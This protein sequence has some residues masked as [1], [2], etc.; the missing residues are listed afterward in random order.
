MLLLSQIYSKDAYKKLYISI[1]VYHRSVEQKKTK[2][3]FNHLV[4]SKCVNYV[5][6]RNNS[7]LI[8][9]GLRVPVPMHQCLV[10]SLVQRVRI[11]DYQGYNESGGAIIG[12]M[13]IVKSLARIDIAFL[14]YLSQHISCF[15]IAATFIY[16]KGKAAVA[17][18][19]LTVS[20]IISRN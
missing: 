4:W 19:V 1:R 7:Q 8:C 3:Q 16:L 10:S 5:Q 12:P 9:N 11:H 17:L 2:A 18:I 15:Y 20:K 14:L 6:N 13:H